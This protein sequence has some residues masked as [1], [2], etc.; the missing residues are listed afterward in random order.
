MNSQ[1]YFGNY[2]GIVVQNNDPLKRGRVK[3]YIPHIT[4]TAYSNWSSSLSATD[5]SFKFPGKNVDSSLSTIIDELKKILPWSEIAAPLVGESSNGR[6]NAPK[7]FG[8][9]SDSD[10]IASTFYDSGKSKS[11]T[12]QTNWGSLNY[13]SENTGTYSQNKDKIGEK[14]G[15]LLTL[16]ITD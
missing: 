3:V 4:P 9:I 8:T 15:N 12:Q 13:K 16:I 1:R 7:D 2:L 11:D 14:P 5:K 6:Y 10:F